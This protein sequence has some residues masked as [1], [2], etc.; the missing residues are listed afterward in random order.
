MGFHKGGSTL[1]FTRSFDAAIVIKGWFALPA[2]ISR[3]PM[4]HLSCLAIE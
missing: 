2:I 1:L 3:A 4:A